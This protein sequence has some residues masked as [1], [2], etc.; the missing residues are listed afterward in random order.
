MEPWPRF[1]LTEISRRITG[2][3]VTLFHVHRKALSMSEPFPAGSE[4]PHRAEPNT[5]RAW[6]PGRA[7]TVFERLSLRLSGRPHGYG[8]T[9]LLLL[10]VA[11]CAGSPPIAIPPQNLAQTSAARTPLRATAPTRSP[12]PRCGRERVAGTVVLALPGGHRALFSAP[13][14]DD[15]HHRLPLVVGLSGYGQ[16]AED[17]AAQTKIPARAT[18][19]GMLSVL[20]Q[21]A[22]KAKSWNLSDTTGNDDVALLSALVT[23]LAAS[24]CADPDRVVI[25]GISDGGDMAVFAACALP[26]RFRAVVTVAASIDPQAGCH[27]IR[28][29]AVHGD[30]DPVDPYLGKPASPGYLA[31]PPASAAIAAWAALDGC[32]TGSTT[33]GAPHIAVTTY[34]CGAQLVTVN[35]GGHTWPGG[36]SVN[37]SLG[38]ISSE[39]DATAKILALV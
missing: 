38:V 24:E 25:T 28:I 10:A 5:V 23:Q 26:G 3:V 36:T 9:V 16:T 12:E 15:G 6:P 29:V 11:G 4:A 27:P 14:G 19:A 8:A 31:T 18:S 34:P 22:G 32:S 2:H 1:P 21:G 17:L 37:P 33:R 20:P 35:G 39:Y 7:A 13:A 30:A